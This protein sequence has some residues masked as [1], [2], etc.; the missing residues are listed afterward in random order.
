[1]L[2]ALGLNDGLARS[3]LRFSL[4]RYTTEEEIDYTIEQ[5]TNAVNKLRVMSPQHES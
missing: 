2:R 3:S 1:V 4:G 5:V